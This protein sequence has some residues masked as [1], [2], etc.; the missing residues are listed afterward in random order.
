MG[1]FSSASRRPTPLWTL[2]TRAVAANAASSTSRCHRSPA[3]GRALSLLGD[4]AG[5]GAQ[6]PVWAPKP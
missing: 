2:R 3:P 5:A 6:R 4:G 1:S